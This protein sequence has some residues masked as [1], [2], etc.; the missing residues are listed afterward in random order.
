MQEELV[1]VRDLEPKGLADDAVEARAKLLV[2]GFF[3]LSCCSLEMGLSGELVRGSFQ[4]ALSSI[5][6]CGE[7][8]EERQ[9]ARSRQLH[10]TER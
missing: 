4:V 1:L 7:T 3:D 6:G 5:R 8:V 10:V 2:D 9:H